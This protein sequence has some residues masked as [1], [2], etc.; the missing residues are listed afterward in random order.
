MIKN[1]LLNIFLYLAF[2][3]VH[4]AEFLNPDGPKKLQEQIKIVK[5]NFISTY[6][7]NHVYYYYNDNDAIRLGM[8]LYVDSKNNYGCDA[9]PKV[10][11]YHIMR[12][13]DYKKKKL[14]QQEVNNLKNIN[15]KI[16]KEYTC[17][18]GD[19]YESN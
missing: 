9:L 2:L 10:L 11:E 18:I 6:C 14:S 13:L 12:A 19:Y 16:I 17:N 3:N 7:G 15:H 5:I 8:V 4:C 1:L